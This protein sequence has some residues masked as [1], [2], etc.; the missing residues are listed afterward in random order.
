[1][2]Y[3]PAVK[4]SWSLVGAEKKTLRKEILNNSYL[5]KQYGHKV[6]VN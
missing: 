4:N 6:M 5:S 1:M 3:W 2:I